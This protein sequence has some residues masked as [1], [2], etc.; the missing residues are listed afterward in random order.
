M[1]IVLFREEVSAMKGILQTAFIVV[2]LS[3]ISI[4]LITVNLLREEIAEGENRIVA[5][6]PDLFKED[7]RLNDQYN[8]E[9][10]TWIN[11]NIGY[12]SSMVVNYAKLQYYLFGNLVRQS[13]MYLGPNGELNY[14]TEAMLKDYQH[15]DLYSEEYLHTF[16]DS[17]QVLSDYA[18]AGGAQFY[19]Y[20]CWDKHSIYPEYFPETVV[21]TGAESKTDGIVRALRDYSEVRVISPKQELTDEKPV[22]PTYS[23]W[24][25]PAHWNQR[26]A[27]VGYLKLMNTINEY[28][29]DRY[30]VLQ[31]SDYII[32]KPDQGETLFGRIHRTEYI[33][34]L[35]I[36]APKAVPTGTMYKSHPKKW[37]Q[38][39]LINEEADNDTRL[40]V[41]GDSY[42][43]YFLI[44]DLAESFHET[45]FIWSEALP[46]FRKIVDTYHADIIVVEAAER[47]DR[48]G[49]IIKTA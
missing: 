7:G 47:A 1:A 13:N 15:D 12:R 9:F 44:D 16:A 39:V 23:V 46:D 11:D 38:R 3:M 33:E 31:E 22:N 32:T 4:P 34:D 37:K 6:L 49:M 35:K 36:K 20:Q 41:I 8:R 40:L 14:A 21:Q 18:E 28:S 26:G 25:D 45:I 27:Y 17:M 29:D 5:P 10:E 2:F 24:G 43:N 42:F 30:K 19:Y 48:T